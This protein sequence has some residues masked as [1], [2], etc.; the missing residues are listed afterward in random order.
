[1]AADVTALLGPEDAARVPLKDQDAA[2][3]WRLTRDGDQVRLEGDGD[4]L[5]ALRLLCGVCWDGVDPA[6][7]HAGS[8]RASEV[9]SSWGLDG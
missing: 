4:R 7:V 2:G 3:G 8:D 1:V 6:D 9:L 5:D